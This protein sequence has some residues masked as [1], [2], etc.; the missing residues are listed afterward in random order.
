QN[1]GALSGSNLSGNLGQNFSSPV[2]APPASAAPPA[3]P[4]TL[5]GTNRLVF[6]NDLGA[7]LEDMQ[8]D[9][10]ELLPRLAGLAGLT[11]S[12][13]GSGSGSNLDGS[14]RSP[15]AAIPPA[16][17]TGLRLAPGTTSRTGKPPP[18]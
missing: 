11:N 16:S 6:L 13:N 12:N 17:P 8:S 2:A 5:S 14:A 18:P 1:F 9:L 3:T 15:V 7:V 4:P 10:Q